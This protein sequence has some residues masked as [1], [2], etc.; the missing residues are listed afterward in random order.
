MIYVTDR[1]KKEYSTLDN[2]LK[3]EVLN[4]VSEINTLPSNEIP[5]YLDSLYL[6]KRGRSKW[7]GISKTLYHLYPQSYSSEHR[8]FYCYASDLENDELMDKSNL[9]HEDIIFIA[10]T[11]NHQ[12]ADQEAKRYNKS[13]IDY[14]YEFKP[15]IEYDGLTKNANIPSFWFRLTD[16]QYEVLSIEQPAS[17]KGSAGTGK[18]FISFELLKEWIIN[19]PNAKILYLTYTDRLLDKVKTTLKYDGLD[20]NHENI[21]I[22]KFDELLSDKNDYKVIDE[23]TAR[24]IIKDI[25]NNF[26]KFNPR[27]KQDIIFTDYFVYS[28]IRGLMKGRIQDLDL[29]NQNYEVDNKGLEEFLKTLDLGRELSKTRNVLSEYLNNNFLTINEFNKKL[30]PLISSGSKNRNELIGRLYSIFNETVIT[31]I[32]SFRII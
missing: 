15:P 29:N 19:D 21:N 8:I 30:I 14:L 22:Y 6:S 7:T 28:Y 16:D 31:K 12:E 11:K 5:G 9:Y 3:D 26:Y 27:F 17:V 1:F 10:Y 20:I 23:I 2:E 24:N 25:L 13:T 4:I 18:T 32:N